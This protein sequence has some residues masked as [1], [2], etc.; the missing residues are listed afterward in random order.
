MKS[1]FLPGTEEKTIGIT[2]PV[3]MDQQLK[4]ALDRLEAAVKSLEDAG[5]GAGDDA[6]RRREIAGIKELVGEAIELLG[7][8]SE[9]RKA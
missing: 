2:V 7:A 1:G 4:K 9:G 6:A 3:A 5:I 8:S